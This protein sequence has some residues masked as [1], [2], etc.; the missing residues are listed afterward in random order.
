MEGVV[1]NEQPIAANNRRLIRTS[2]PTTMR[3]N[4]VLLGHCRRVMACD[5]PLM[6]VPFVG[7]GIA[8][9]YL[10]SVAESKR[11]KPSVDCRVAVYLDRSG[12]DLANRA[13]FQKMFKV[14]LPG[15]RSKARRIR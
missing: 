15:R 1:P 8:R 4:S 14:I 5:Q 6:A 9:L 3:R 12:V 10:T 2:D 11:V 13:I 7:V